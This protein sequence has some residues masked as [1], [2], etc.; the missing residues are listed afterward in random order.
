MILLV[1]KTYGCRTF[2]PCA[3]PVFR[4]GERIN[5]STSSPI[6]ADHRENRI[7]RNTKTVRAGQGRRRRRRQ[8]T[9]LRY[10]RGRKGDVK[11]SRRASARTPERP[12]PCAVTTTTRSSR[13][14]LPEG[15][16]STACV[17]QR[18]AADRRSPVGFVVVVTQRPVVLLYF[19]VRA[20]NTYHPTR[21]SV[22]TCARAFTFFVNR[23]RRRA[24]NTSTRRAPVDYRRR[25]GPDIFVSRQHGSVSFRLF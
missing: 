15:H 21:V 22:T 13:G 4:I 16:A 24:A 1:V 7:W 5:T 25:F 6:S 18:A 19:I 17:A 10:R 11:W 14:S 8:H 9:V 12:V 20:R 2:R 23:A 3:G